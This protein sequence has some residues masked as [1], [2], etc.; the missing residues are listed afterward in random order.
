[1][2]NPSDKSLLQSCLNGDRQAWDRL[3]LRYERLVYNIALR[4]GLSQEDCADVFQ[5]V[6][7]LLM[8]NLDKL[9]DDYNVAGWLTTTTR[10]ECLRVLK[11]K[12]RTASFTEMKGEDGSSPV[13]HSPATDPL[14]LESLLSLE[15]EQAVRIAMEELG[16][17]CRRLLELLYQTDPRPSYGEVARQFDIAEGAVGPK[18]ARC[19]ITLR[20][21]LRRHGF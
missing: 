8:N 5:D 10:W 16:E 15:Q 17:S 13:D 12:K 20:K 14:P 9:T 18:R 3:I 21:I 11:D 19:L 4:A 1:V 7:L 6:C 2:L